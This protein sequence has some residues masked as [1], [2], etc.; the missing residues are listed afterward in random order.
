MSVL[1]IVKLVA[2]PGLRVS[3]LE[4][5]R[6]AVSATREQPACTSVELVCGI[7]NEEVLLLVERWQSVHDH[8]D[9][10]NGVIA[11]G[12][13][14]EVMDLLAADIETSHYR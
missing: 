14:D 12:G 8:E 7:E 6:P 3:L 13:L 9:F 4:V 5:I 2:K 11:T 10:I 1:A